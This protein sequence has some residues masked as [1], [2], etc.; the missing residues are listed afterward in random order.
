MNVKSS[1]LQPGGRKDDSSPG[2]SVP[3][4][5]AQAKP[6]GIATHYL[7]YSFSNAFVLLAGVVS[8]PILTRVLSNTEYG[9]LRYYDALLL[10]GV[11]VMKL[12]SQHTLIRFYPYDGD[13]EELRSFGA[14][15][16]MLPM[17]MSAA[18]WMVGAIA[19]A[20]W[21]DVTGVGLHPVFWCVVVMMPMLAANSIVQMVARARERSD[22][23]MKT[24]VAGRLTELLLVLAAVLLV[25][26]TAAAAYTAKLVATLAMFAWFLDWMRRNVRIERSAIDLRAFRAGLLFGLPMMATELSS[27]I[28]NNL[29][30]VLLKEITGDFAVAGIYAIGYSLA[31]QV[32]MF[33]S[34]T[35]SEAF[36]PAVT[37]AYE[38]GG[39]A[40]V[41]ALKAR[42]L[43]LLT[44]AVAAIVS[45]LIVCGQDLLVTL[46]GADKAASGSVFV[47]VGIT[48]S[49]YAWFDV[50]S[51]GLLL[52]NRSLLMLGIMA[53]AAALNVALNFILVPGMG[54]VGA[55][56]ATAASYAALAALLLVVCPKGLVKFPRPRTILTALGCAA[57]FVYV[58]Q[59]SDLFGMEEPLFRLFV[60]AILFMGFY[61]VPVLAMDG[62]LRRSLLSFRRGAKAVPDDRK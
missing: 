24:R 51:Y 32:N 48:V 12:G 41:V 19:L 13:P 62:Q 14:N 3:V 11:A 58:A 30:R 43:H 33:I 1:V 18:V 28:L 4:A 60:T 53:S 35:L 59:A 2:G 15:M 22:I 39:S 23:V 49:V 56:W 26:A 20:V 8:F 16:V 10:L 7:R 36:T 44:Y 42:V 17:G 9:I 34:A 29:D 25:Q 5:P 52:K 45:L 27:S 46:S 47:I 31:M 21:H 6:P 40:Q 50:A 37:R 57:F 55:A 38:V 61:A 54:Y